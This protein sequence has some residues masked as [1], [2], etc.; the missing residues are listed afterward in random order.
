M[1]ALLRSAVAASTDT[2]GLRRASICIHE[3]LYFWNQ[4]CGSFGFHVNSVPAY[5]VMG[6]HATGSRSVAMPLKSG[7]ATPM[8]V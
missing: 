8:I 2:P 5:V 3:I 4:L 7:G 1:K 6:I